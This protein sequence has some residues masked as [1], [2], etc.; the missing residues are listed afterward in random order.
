[1]ARIP[2]E[3]L[4][5]LKREAGL[6]GVCRRRGVELKV[7]GE[8]LVGSCPFH[9]D[10]E[11]SFVVTPG[12]NLWH[13]FGACGRGGD[14]IAFVMGYEK[15]SFRHAVEMLRREM[16]EGPAASVLVT[17]IG[18]EHP[19][20]VE[21]DTELTD[22]A[23]LTRVAEFYHQT[24]LS[25]SA[26]AKGMKYLQE[27]GVFSVEAINTFKLGLAN[28]TLG[29]RVPE[30]TAH[31]AKLKA[32]LQKVGILRETG[33]EHLTGCVVFPITNDT[34]E[35]VEM[36]GRRLTFPSREASKHL[37]LPGP[38]AGVWNAAG[39]A[40][41][42]EW[43]LCEALIDAL[44][45]WVNGFRHVTASYGVNGFTPDHWKLLRQMKPRRV[46]V[47]YDNDEGGNRAA[48]EL[49]QQLE[50]EGVEAWR[51]ELRP[52]S[53]INDL[54]RSAE[55]PKAAL[56]SLLAA[57]RRLLP[58]E[59]PVVVPVPVLPGER[60]NGRNGGPARETPA[61]ASLADSP[62]RPVADPSLPTFEVLH[63][64]KQ[65]E[66][67]IGGRSYRVR[68]LE[69]NTGFD[70]LKVNVRAAYGAGGAAGQERFHVDTLDLY[71]A[72]QRAAFV[73]AGHQ[74]LGVP[75]ATVEA[76]LTQLMVRLEQHQEQAIL[77]KTKVPDAVAVGPKMT[78]EEEAK[79][80][81]LLREPQLFRR[82]LADFELAGVV[83]EETNKLL[84]YLIAVS[85]KLNK[86]LSGQITA[87]S[88][89]GKS[90]LLNAIL[91]F[92]PA[93]DKQVVTAMTGQALY[94]LPEEGLQ[95]KVLAIV[96]DEGSQQ[97][98]YPLKILQS[99]NE[100]ILAVTVKDPEGGMPQ[101]QLKRVKGPV[102]QF[103][104]STRP[105]TDYELENRYLILSVDEGRQQTQ[106]IHAAQR[107][108]ETL[109]GLLRALDRE[110]V[111]KT[112]HNAQRLLR[113]LRVNN[114]F[115]EALTF[116]DHQLRLRR[117]H[118]KYLGLIRT[119]AFLR[120]YQ[121]PIKSCEHRGQ[122][123]QYIE[124][125]L[126]DVKLVHALAVEVLGRSL[127]EL[128]PP[129]RSFLVALHGMVQAVAK[130]RQIPLDAV[131][132]SRREVREGIGWSVTQVREHLEKLLELEYVVCHRVPGPACRWEYELVWDGQGQDG[133]VFINGLA[134]L[135][136]LATNAKC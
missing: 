63:E 67:R 134:P 115:A 53:D 14:V 78:P 80:L 15:V 30:A 123:L 65:A 71:N 122:S 89:A 76:D 20:L 132:F 31:G 129:T 133:G 108:E 28:R 38:H 12:K 103:T 111:L 23:L 4:E 91:D 119:T 90:S 49:A 120:Q 55:D 99:E 114:P 127:D 79:A 42:D 64:G 86:P 48:N 52:H 81:A 21:P 118:K 24:L 128:S 45:L 35:I 93:E 73:A 117:D 62:A 26:G 11:P 47:C 112:H 110:E 96:E 2:D 107:E 74:I 121:K 1:M 17:R 104:T 44:S 124:V 83:G 97:A 98:S 37:Y 46:I 125:D 59:R 75:K 136:K 33:H 66:L 32:Q 16:G 9:E 131:R 135:A 5:R 69:N 85:R 13:C 130:E 29:Y 10:R 109:R 41:R 116:P 22:A 8:N 100:L 57:A 6:E 61:S 95:H 92:V 43:L 54:V 25:T 101:T 70:Q 72:R 68:G 56:A 3:E 7:Q 94:Y 40:G 60:A 102:A 113:P 84:G 77:A 34:G 82:L 88:A 39:L 126:E 106:R 50:P 58:T 36:Y 87:R 105:E 19:V 18:T 27:R 51:V